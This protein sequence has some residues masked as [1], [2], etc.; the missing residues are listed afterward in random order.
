MKS[1]RFLTKMILRKLDDR[2]VGLIER[3]WGQNMFL[4]I[5]VRSQTSWFDKQN[6]GFLK[7]AIFLWMQSHKLLCSRII[8]NDKN[9]YF[10]EYSDPIGYKW[11]NVE[12]LGFS[13]DKNST[14]CS[15][16]S[17]YVSK[18]LCEQILSDQIDPKTNSDCLLWKFYIFELDANGYVYDIISLFHHTITQGKTGFLNLCQLLRIFESLHKNERVEVSTDDVIFEG[19]DKLFGFAKIFEST[20]ADV[21]PV[22][23]PSF[24]NSDRAFASCSNISPPKELNDP[25]TQ[26]IRVETRELFKSIANLIDNSRLNFIKYQTY[27]L[28]KTLIKKSNSNCLNS[29]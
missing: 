12:F 6:L 22:I 14:S 21:R 1:N 19:Y 29:F 15:D 4:K 20:P 27:S 3:G 7:N 13:Y 8:R 10:F 26:I 23:C 2:E 25:K 11:Q 16:I 9:E 24:V 18:L 28:G 17:E 5:R